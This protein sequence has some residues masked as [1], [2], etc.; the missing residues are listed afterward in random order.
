MEEWFSLECTKI[1]VLDRW[2]PDFQI[3]VN[4]LLSYTDREIFTLYLIG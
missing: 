1:F 3:K 2:L 4:Y